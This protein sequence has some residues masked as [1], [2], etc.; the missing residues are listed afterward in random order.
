MKAK[1]FQQNHCEVCGELLIYI[2]HW[3]F[4]GSEQGSFEPYWECLNG[5]AYPEVPDNELTAEELAER[6]KVD[7]MTEFGIIELQQERGAILL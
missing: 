3:E 2:E 6:N 4:D 1:L 5:C 7:T